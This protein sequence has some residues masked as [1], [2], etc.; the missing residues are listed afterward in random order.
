[1]G[2]DRKVAKGTKIKEAPGTGGKIRPVD[3]RDL[4]VVATR[5]TEQL[6]YP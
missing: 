1:M 3:N 2:R 5:S 4:Q 6:K